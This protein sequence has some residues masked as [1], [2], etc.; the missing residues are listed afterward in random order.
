MSTNVTLQISLSPGDTRIVR[1]TIPNLV[2][3]HRSN[4]DLSLAIVDL[5]RPQR[6]RLFDPGSIDL[7]KRNEI[8]QISYDMQREGLFDRIILLNNTDQIIPYIREKYLANKIKGTH[9]FRGAGMMSYLAGIE[10]PNTRYVLHYDCDML[11]YQ[12]DGYDW[13]REA[14]DRMSKYPHIVVG[15]PRTSPPFEGDGSTSDGPSQHERRPFTPISGGWE[16]DWFNTQCFLI[17]KLKLDNYLPLIGGITLVQHYIFKYI[18]KS[19][20]KSPEM[21]MIR[22]IGGSGGRRLILDSKK[23]W[24][25]HPLHK[26][27]LFYELLPGI[28]NNIG[29]NNVPDVQKG[30]P[31][32]VLEAWRDMLVG[33]SKY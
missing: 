25:I 14:I 1:N 21:L 29:R 9:D 22:K 28:Q 27:D 7:N 30:D 18:T 16:N 19:L 11:L 8:I 3:R 26:P 2:N 12:E 24:I 20:P 13:S 31:N 17:D 15:V 4:V 6:T 33:N 10:I 5:C 23:A 32:L